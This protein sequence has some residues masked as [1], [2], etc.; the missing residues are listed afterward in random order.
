MLN[1]RRTLKSIYLGLGKSSVI[2]PS[3]FLV[4][5]GISIV[6]LGIIFYVTEVFNASPSQVGYFIA[7]WCVT[8]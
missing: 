8:C 5:T 3:A 6:E 2:Y 4:A 7:L 1:K